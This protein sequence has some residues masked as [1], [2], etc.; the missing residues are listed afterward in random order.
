M[1][2][3]H[4]NDLL[5][6]E[7]PELAPQTMYGSPP[8]QVQLSSTPDDD[9]FSQALAMFAVPSSPPRNVVKPIATSGTDGGGPPPLIRQHSKSPDPREPVRRHSTSREPQDLS[10]HESEFPIKL[11]SIHHS[12]SESNIPRSAIAASNTV[13]QRANSKQNMRNSSNSSK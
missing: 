5:L 13:H 6:D 10:D 4:K 2:V 8:P 12:V 1:L 7:D 3:W 11:S 9:S